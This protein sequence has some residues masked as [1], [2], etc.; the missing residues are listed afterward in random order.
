MLTVRQWRNVLLYA[1][2]AALGLGAAAWAL[3]LWHADLRVPFVYEGDALLNLMI[4]KNIIENGW[5]LHTDALGAP[6]GMM[7]YDFAVGDNLVCAMIKGMSFFISDPVLLTN[8]FF[9]LTFPLVSLTAFFTGRQFGLSAA[10]A[11]LFSFLY[12]LLPYHFWRGTTHLFFSAYFL[13]PPAILITWWISSGNLLTHRWRVWFSLG[14]SALLGCDGV[15]HPFFACFFFVLAAGLAWRRRDGRHALAG[16]GLIAVIFVAVL[17]NLTPN[18]F[19]ARK[20]GAAVSG[21]RYSFESEVAALKIAQLILPV[22]GHRIPAFARLKANYNA[23]HPLVNGN[24]WVSLGSIGSAGFLVLT[25]WVLFIRR[26]AARAGQV[27]P[28]HFGAL[29]EDLSIFNVAAVLLATIGGFSALFAVLVTPQIRGYNRISPFIAYFSLLTVALGLEHFARRKV[30]SRTGMIGFCAALAA[31]GLLGLLDQTGGDSQHDW[32]ALKSQFTSDRRF[33]A[34]VQA[35]LP[36]GAMVFELPY[37]PFPEYGIMNQMKDYAPFRPY[38]HTHG[39]RWSYGVIKGRSGDVWEQKTAAEPPERMVTDLRDDGFAGVYVDRAGYADNGA[40]LEAQLR[41][42][43]GSDP[44]SDAK[45]RFLF[46]KLPP[47]PRGKVQPPFLVPLAPPQW[48]GGFYDLETSA[49]G[50]TNWRW[51]ASTGELRILNDTSAI[52]AVRLTALLRCGYEKP[53][54][55]R[56]EGDGLDENFVIHPSGVALS[57]QISVQPGTT[58]L[59]FFCDGDPLPKNSNDPRTLVWRIEDFK[60]EDVP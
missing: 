55:L 9:L 31:L 60:M 33:F 43:I 47:L 14:V 51:C 7:L 6:A 41:G 11:L 25:G 23:T 10:P 42:V 32:H 35:S 58:L 40:A 50:R 22:T 4:V 8:L 39:L 49:D 45:G 46:F 52:H 24:D 1:A 36:A 19:Y 54:H 38:F 29:I 30:K 18:I 37:L 17:L 12:T 26:P 5:Y 48:L 2:A 56:I 34:K 57:K 59:R 16:A 28:G 44:M 21:R 53:T 27:S 15:Y 13:L 20:Y 3:N